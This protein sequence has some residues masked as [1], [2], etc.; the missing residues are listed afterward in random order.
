MAVCACAQAGLG[1][2]WNES[3]THI[4]PEVSLLVASS[5]YNAFAVVMQSFFFLDDIETLN[6]HKGRVRKAAMCLVDESRLGGLGFRANY[7]RSG[8]ERSGHGP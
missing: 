3:R 1:P 5:L 4:G 8:Q 6:L 2:G 7:L